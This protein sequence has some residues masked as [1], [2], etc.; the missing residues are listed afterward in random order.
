MQASTGRFGQQMQAWQRMMRRAVS[1]LPA[2]LGIAGLLLSSAY[3]GAV[4]IRSSGPAAVRIGVA[5]VPPVP[6]TPAARLYTEEG[7]EADLAA[8]IGKR[9]GRP[10]QIIDIGEDSGVSGLASG[11]LDAVVTRAGDH[12]D[13]FASAEILP[14]GY[15]SGL[16]VSMRSDTQ[17][18]DWQDLAGRTVCVSAANRHAQGVAQ[19]AG[20]K[21]LVQPVPALSLMRVRTGE[22]D[23][24][25][26][27]EF[28][29]G[30]LFGDKEWKKFSATLPA[31]ESTRLVVVLPHEPNPL[32]AQIRQIVASVASE[33]AWA[34]RAQRWATDVAFEIYLD[35]DGPDCH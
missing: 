13:R 11:R 35:Q 12:D 32:T 21:V 23:A 34:A 14:T 20:A 31:R 4:E 25:L 29:L 8:D 1:L 18:R 30:R 5:Y 10:V 28:V 3:S 27:D 17:I 26:H 24:A 22:C 7:F 16:S 9:L 2:S 15:A 33:N 6:A 19:A